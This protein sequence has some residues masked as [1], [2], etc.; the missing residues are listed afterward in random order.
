MNT[1]R[2]VYADYLYSGMVDYWGGDGRRWDDNAACLFAWYSRG[3]TLKGIIED[4]VSDA[5]CGS[6]AEKIPEDITTD[7]IRTALLDML[8]DSGMRDYESGA[9]YLPADCL[10]DD[11]GMS[12]LPVMIVLL[13]WE[14]ERNE[15]C[16][17]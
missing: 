13:T 11:D 3:T 9:A 16:P 12:E 4:L 17:A 15:P 5:E 14:V 2:T 1:T 7:S 10:D 8:S 6:D